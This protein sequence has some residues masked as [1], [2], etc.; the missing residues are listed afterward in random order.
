MYYPFLSTDSARDLCA[1]GDHASL[2]AAVNFVPIIS[3]GCSIDHF[4]REGLVEVLTS[5]QNAGA[6]Y[7]LVINPRGE[8]TSAAPSDMLE[9]IA[10]C[11]G[12]LSRLGVAVH[13]T[14]NMNIEEFKRLCGSAGRRELAVIH[15]GFADGQALAALL[16]CVRTDCTHIFD[17]RFSGRLY[18]KAFDFGQHVLLRDGR[19]P[20]VI[21]P[22]GLSRYDE[23]EAP[24]IDFFSDLHATFEEEGAVG[25]GDWLNI[26]DEIGNRYDY[27]RWT[28]RFWLT[29]FGH[30]GA[31]YVYEFRA[32]KE[33]DR[34]RCNSLSCAFDAFAL[35]PL[36]EPFRDDATE[37][38]WELSRLYW[39]NHMWWDR[40]RSLSIAHHVQTMAAY[41]GR[42]ERL[43][44]IAA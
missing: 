15:S 36:G 22:M 34:P 31:M 3:I 12:E 14:E 1:F 2:I 33:L 28:G 26:G 6:R 17:E 42:K 21:I 19:R 32:E 41:F 38:V 29:R 10:E 25:F 20:T 44:C 23:E 9:L 13:A 30:T 39:N 27:F 7:F 16:R 8:N 5:L 37:A 24:D 18:R 11:G 43:V 35:G 40:I 4:R